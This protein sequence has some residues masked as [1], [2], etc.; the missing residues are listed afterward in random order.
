MIREIKAGKTLFGL[1]IDLKDVPIGTHPASD[2]KWSLQLLLMNRK[3]GHT[4]MNHMHKRIVKTTK[5]PQEGLVIIRGEA[6]VVIADRKKKIIGTYTVK[7]GQCLF[8]A[9]GA[10]QVTF[11]KN[12]LAFEF[13]TGPYVADK[14]PLPAV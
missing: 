1:I 8:L 10:H 3:R 7:A 11:T 6:R 2:A 13:K 5:Q 12:S 4:V 14:I 9:D